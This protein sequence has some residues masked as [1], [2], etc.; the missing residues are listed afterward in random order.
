MSTFFLAFMWIQ[1]GFVIFRQKEIG[2][3][4]ALK[5]LVKLTIG[6][7]LD[8]ITFAFPWKKPRNGLIGFSS[9]PSLFWSQ[10]MT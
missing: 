10:K 9:S 2:P 5:M 8:R 3:K 6:V 4:A 1:I 7:G